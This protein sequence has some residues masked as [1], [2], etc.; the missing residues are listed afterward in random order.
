MPLRNPHSP[1]TETAP[2][3]PFLPPSRIALVFGVHR[4]HWREVARG[5]KHFADERGQWRLWDSFLAVRV[6][7]PVSNVYATA[8]GIIAGQYD[9]ESGVLDDARA[10]D[11]PMVLIG[12]VGYGLPV[13][14]P[15]HAA[16]GRLAAKHFAELHLPSVAFC[17]NPP[18]AASQQLEEAFVAEATARGMATSI[19][20]EN[21][22]G[23]MMGYR[24]A[25]DRLVRWLRSLPEPT[26]LLA[27]DSSVAHR[28]TVICRDEGL[29][30]PERIALLG[31]GRDSLLGEIST[32]NLSMIDSGAR[33]T[34]HQAAG[35]LQRLLDGEDVGEINVRVAP[36][37]VVAQASTDLLAVE[38]SAL[39]RAILY[40]RARACEGIRVRDVLRHTRMSRRGLELGFKR[41]LG[42]TIHDEITRVRVE[43]AKNLLAMTDLPIA[44]IAQRC[45]FEWG[46]TLSS[47]FRRVTATTPQ[48]YRKTHGPV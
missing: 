26:G 8:R 2:E 1:A 9:Y 46:S 31:I 48:A 30:I 34:G 27:I 45:G 15:D 20:P 32:P 21:V 25:Y 18:I 17:G 23:S 36:G 43:T 3:S 4:G 35:L 13:V 29:D 10:A 6:G 7:K 39:R 14:G 5:I 19:L 40:V 11:V 24:D 42:R 37:G 12:E 41:C 33:R 38:H 28:L 47:V 44:E 16:I 22:F